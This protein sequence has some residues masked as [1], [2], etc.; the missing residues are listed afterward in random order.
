M[1]DR[2]PSHALQRVAFSDLPGWHHDDH[3]AGFRAFLASA[4]RIEA[5]ASG[6]KELKAASREALEIGKK[7]PSAVEALAFFERRFTPH[8]V[9]RGQPAGLLTGYYEPELSGSR[10][11]TPE[12]PV[13]VLARPPDLVNLVEESE[14]GAKSHQLTHARRTIDGAV[15]PYFTRREIE[16]GALD[17][18]G[19]ELVFLTDAVELFFL[20]VQ[21]SGLVR[22]TDGSALR[23]GYAGKNGH[24]YRSIGRHLIE[25]GVFS[26][27]AMNLEALVH[28]LK[29]DP[30]RAR[31]VMW[32]NQ[33]YVFF[34]ELGLESETRPLGT[35]E[36]ALVPLRSLAVDT[37]HHELGLPIYVSAPGLDH[38]LG[39]P[40]GFH[41]LTVAHDVGSAIMGPERGDLFCGSGRSAGA[42]AGMIKHAVNFF[43]L[44]PDRTDGVS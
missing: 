2:F 3:L 13:P 9:V 27:D 44:L 35:E 39:A 21:G 28:W 36:I 19:L 14:R 34:R 40:G 33:S 24:P 17:G 7:Q 43:V 30:E 4:A 32:L 5:G 26:R 18:R 29:A 37:A 8:R 41:R 6:S 20:Q 31:P 23:L 25:T 10:E 1:A 22:L 11:R 15:E 16:E 42:K 12:F 38:I